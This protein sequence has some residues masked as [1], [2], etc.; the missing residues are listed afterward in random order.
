[1]IGLAPSRPVAQRAAPSTASKPGSA[2]ENLL[3]LHSPDP[4]ARPRPAAA[5]VAA[6]TEAAAAELPPKQSSL[7]RPAVAQVS[8]L[9]SQILKRAAL[10]LIARTDNPSVSTYMRSPLVLLQCSD[11]I[12]LCAGTGPISQRS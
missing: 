9:R 5:S 12:V 10:A 6:G 8:V 7:V 1:M 11:P 4:T 2:E 3:A